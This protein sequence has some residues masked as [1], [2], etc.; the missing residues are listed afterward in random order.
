MT[1]TLTIELDVEVEVCVSPGE[2][3]VRYDR[4]G[5]GHPGSDPEVEVQGM[6]ATLPKGQASRPGETVAL[7]VRLLTEDD[8]DDITEQARDQLGDDRGNEP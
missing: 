4:D 8:I 5:S 6:V 7:D 3:E 2:R 1:V